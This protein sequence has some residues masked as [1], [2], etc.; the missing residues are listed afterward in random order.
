MSR[1]R[2]IVELGGAVTSFGVP[3]VWHLLLKR[4]SYLLGIKSGCGVGEGIRL[5][6]TAVFVRSGLG[7]KRAGGVE[8]AAVAFHRLPEVR[9][10]VYIKGRHRR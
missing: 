5:G 2:E 6:G 10:R 3:V 8:Y 9:S 4:P 1:M 7:C